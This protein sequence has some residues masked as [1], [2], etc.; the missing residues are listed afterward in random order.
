M[1]GMGLEGKGLQLKEWTGMEGNEA[2]R[3]G[4][5][6]TGRAYNPALS[7]RF[8]AGPVSA[9]GLDGLGEDWTGT[10]RRGKKRHGRKRTGQD[11]SGKAHNPSMS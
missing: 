9:N 2:A 6:R 3:R 1:A 7:P 11:W 5:D 4:D 8:T 10:E